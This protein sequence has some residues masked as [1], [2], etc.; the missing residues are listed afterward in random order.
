MAKDEFIGGGAKSTPDAG[1]PAMRSR[2]QEQRAAAKQPAGTA[3]VHEANPG[4]HA[5]KARVTGQRARAKEAA[6]AHSATQADAD[7]R[8][9]DAQAEAAKSAA[10][11]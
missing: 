10:A 8:A 2:V 3:D 9:L 11:K 5:M 6:E 1:L 7:Q 4:L